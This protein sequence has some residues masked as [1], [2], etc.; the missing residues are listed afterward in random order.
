MMVGGW[1]WIKRQF[2]VHVFNIRYFPHW[3]RVISCLYLL[4]QSVSLNKQIV[5]PVF[6]CVTCYKYK[7]IP[8]LSGAFFPHT[9]F[10]SLSILFAAENQFVS[11]QFPVPGDM[12][13]N[14]WKV[15][16]HCLRAFWH[17]HSLGVSRCSPPPQ[18]WI[19]VVFLQISLFPF[20]LITQHYSNSPLI[21]RR[22]DD[23]KLNLYMALKS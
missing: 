7:V 6:T 13:W 16:R 11:N 19:V 14:Q 8:D 17:C 20:R 5:P 10:W 4:S 2:E 1:T 3:S 18:G 21:P 9:A 23:S 15:K 22:T 12:W